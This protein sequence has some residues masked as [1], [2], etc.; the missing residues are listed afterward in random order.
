MPKIFIVKSITNDKISTKDQQ[1]YRLRIVILLFPMK[2]SR[3]DIAN[4]TRELSKANDSA[5][6]AVSKELLNVM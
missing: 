1:E 4:V 2:H 6:S 5:K 3:P